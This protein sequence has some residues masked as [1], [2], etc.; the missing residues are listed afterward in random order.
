MNIRINRYTVES[1]G[2]PKYL[3]E[4][5]RRAKIFNGTITARQNILGI[6]G[7]WAKKQ[8]IPVPKHTENNTETKTPSPAAVRVLVRVVRI[9]AGML[10]SGIKVSGIGYPV[11]G[12]QQVS[13]IRYRVSRGPGSRAVSQQQQQQNQHLADSAAAA[14]IGDR[15][16]ASIRHPAGTVLRENP[17]VLRSPCRR[18]VL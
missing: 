5:S 14:G 11:S 4:L 3:T 13:G 16:R 9:P 7:S 15:R 6:F 8:K 2:A 18:S 12:I 17:C 1:Y 10:V